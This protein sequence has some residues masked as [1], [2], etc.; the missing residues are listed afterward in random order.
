MVRRWRGWEEAVEE[1]YPHAHRRRT[2]LCTAAPR[3]AAACRRDGWWSFRGVVLVPSLAASSGFEIERGGGGATGLRV[4][5]QPTQS[6]LPRSREK[7]H[8]L[9]SKC[10]K[11]STRALCTPSAPSALSVP[12]TRFWR[13]TPKRVKFRQ[14]NRTR[15]KHTARWPHGGGALVVSRQSAPMCR[16]VYRVI[17]RVTCTCTCPLVHCGPVPLWFLRA[18][19]LFS[20]AQPHAERG[21][22]KPRECSSHTHN[23]SCPWIKPGYPHL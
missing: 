7:K 10:S 17:D 4:R 13:P 19:T 23:S 8:S 15:D 6:F 1:K 9:H 20:T 11:S 18:I 22:L 21:N 3:A 2:S 12:R 5:C 16:A 14:K